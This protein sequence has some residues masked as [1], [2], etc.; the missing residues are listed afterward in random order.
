MEKNEIT[1]S[2]PDSTKKALKEWTER[3]VLDLAET[4]YDKLIGPEIEGC[5]YEL[6]DK[7][8]AEILEKL[9]KKKVRVEGNGL[10]GNGI[11]ATMEE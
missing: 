10:D 2:I 9:T 4:I 7:K 8:I 11:R 5:P 1:F 6:I 3:E